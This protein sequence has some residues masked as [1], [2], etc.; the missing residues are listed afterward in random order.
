MWSWMSLE[1]N[2][3]HYWPILLFSD[4]E[5]KHQHTMVPFSNISTSWALASWKVFEGFI[6]VSGGPYTIKGCNILLVFQKI[7]NCSKNIEIL[8]ILKNVN[9]IFWKF[10]ALWKIFPLI[11]TK[12]WPTK[13]KRAPP[14]QNWASS[15]KFIDKIREC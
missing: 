14:N 10:M 5:K 13:K 4:W 2:V 11:F 15:N 9:F 6:W 12:F 1:L 3:I 7:Q 8:K